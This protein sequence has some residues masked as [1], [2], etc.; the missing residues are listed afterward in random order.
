[1]GLLYCGVHAPL[2]ALAVVLQGVEDTLPLSTSVHP[3][4]VLDQPAKFRFLKFLGLGVI[5][6]SIDA[7]V[8]QSM[9][10]GLGVS[11]YLAR[12]ASFVVATSSAWW[13]NRTFAFRDAENV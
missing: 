5:A 4:A 12:I 13:M 7:I 11:P 1:M 6:F 3:H 10:S 2:S 8:F 9:V